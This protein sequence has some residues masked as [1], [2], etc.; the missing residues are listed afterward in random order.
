M[1]LID[2]VLEVDDR[3]YFKLGH[4]EHFLLPNYHLDMHSFK[5]IQH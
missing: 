3:S 1:D 5:N 2:T 4:E